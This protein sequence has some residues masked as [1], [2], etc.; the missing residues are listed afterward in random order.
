MCLVLWRASSAHVFF[1]FRVAAFV[2]V[3]RRLFLRSALWEPVLLLLLCTE[4][5]IMEGYR[6]E[7]KFFP[8]S[9]GLFLKFS[10]LEH[11]IGFAEGWGRIT[12]DG[13][14]WFSSSLFVSTFFLKKEQTKADLSC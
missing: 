11:P 14:L 13:L 9:R 2:C 12:G 10:S 6:W 3:P 7:R 4:M 1:S 8:T 5:E